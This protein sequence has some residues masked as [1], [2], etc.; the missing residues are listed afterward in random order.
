MLG[1]KNP[2]GKFFARA[3]VIL[4]TGFALAAA[5]CAGFGNDESL[6]IQVLESGLKR[7]ENEFQRYKRDME[8]RV[9]Q[10]DP[11]PGQLKALREDFD[12]LRRELRKGLAD[13]GDRVEG[14]RSEVSVLT[15]RF[16]EA[17][18]ESKKGAEGVV[19]LKEEVSPKVYFLENQVKSQG[20]ALRS[21]ERATSQ[22]QF[23][24]TE[25]D[26]SITA[27]KEESQKKLSALEQ[28]LAKLETQAT[29]VA[30][31]PSPSPVAGLPP[32][33]KPALKPPTPME[34]AY[35]EAFDLF[36]AGQYKAAREKFKEFARS[37]PDSPLL[38]NAKFW[39]AESSYNLKNY[40]EA[41]LEYDDLLTKSPDGEN[42]PTAM[43]KQG[44]AFLE[45]GDKIDARLVLNR[46]RTK[47]PG[48]E[49]A[50]A[51]ESKLKEI[52]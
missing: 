24:L 3:K 30:P 46:V 36:T 52:K 6:R 26:K 32:A 15:G 47:F 28:G 19:A 23:Q 45:L 25:L 44:L 12:G 13:L 4:L 33:A 14:Y 31:S 7:Q 51:A 5:G 50:R 38:S 40:E 48:T 9:T 29:S 2:R 37:Y 39:A 34:G 43:L 20:D 8:P 18:F 11:V 21:L 27:F 41:I 1:L 35:Q 17:K 42:A 22:V 16:E 10:L 49:Q